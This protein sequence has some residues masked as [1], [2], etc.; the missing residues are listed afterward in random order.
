M[1]RRTVVYVAAL[2]SPP[3]R[4]VARPGPT[5]V[6]GLP[7]FDLQ[8]HSTASDGHL[9][10]AVVVARA[11]A[12]GV[13][14]LALT[15]HDTVAGLTEATA[16]AAGTPGLRLV[17]GVEITAIDEGVEDLHVCG[18]GFDRGAPALLDALHDW[19]ADRTARGWRMVEAMRAEG[20]SIDDASLRDRERRG[21]SIGRPHIAGDV[22]VHP[23]NAARLRA[24]GL[25]TATDILVAYLVPGRAGYRTRTTPTVA[26]AVSAVHD[27]GGVAVWAHPFWDFS[28]PEAV[29]AT[30]RRHRA[31]GM[32]GVEAFYVTHDE[33]QTRLLVAE[34]ERLGM[35]TT[36][37]ADFH[38]DEHPH[39]S[40]FRAFSLHGLRPNLGPIVGA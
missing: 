38:G 14:T 1:R 37:S 21:L 26:E 28:D 40:R 31:L 10:P 3:R 18:Y 25:A 8:A 16:A 27:A 29:L 20:W 11:H 15:D 7:D 35:L 13:R 34:A 32:D 2:R 6:P 12:A 4:R 24:E 23:D 39:F 19:N 22:L 5:P 9:D 17:P 36:G 30:L 33:A